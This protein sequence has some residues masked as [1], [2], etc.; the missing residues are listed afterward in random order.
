MVPAKFA[1]AMLAP[2]AGHGQIGRRGYPR[3]HAV[4][5]ALWQL[6]GVLTQAPCAV[7]SGTA[8]PAMVQAPPG[9][10]GP[11]PLWDSPGNVGAAI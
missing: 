5:R 1:A 7:L 2:E 4:G 6:A 3:G 11:V 10:P 8:R 9:E